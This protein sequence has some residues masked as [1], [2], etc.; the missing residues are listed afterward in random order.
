MQTVSLQSV[1]SV[2][3]RAPA[4][5]ARYRRGF[6]NRSA[7]FTLV[8]LC[9][10][11]VL[12]LVAAEAPHF[13]LL[14][15][16]GYGDVYVLHSVQQFQRTGT[17]YQDTSQP[18]YVPSVYSPAV[19]L[20][21]ALP[22]R[23][24]E[25]GNPFVLP[26]V[27][28]LI[29]FLLCVALTASIAHVL[30]PARSAWFWG[31]AM[32]CSVSAM[33]G[34]VLMLR[35]DFPG[36]VFSLLAIRLLIGKTRFAPALAGIAA[37]L[38][39]QFKFTFIAALAAGFLWLFVRRRWRDCA[40]F[41]LSGC[42]VSLGGYFLF[43]L[44]EPRMLAQILTFHHPLIDFPGLLVIIGQVLHEPVLLLGVAALPIV[45]RRSCPRW[46]LWMTFLAASLIVAAVTDLQAG[47]A[48]NYFY[49]A[50]FAITPLAVYTVL[51]LRSLPLPIAALCISLLL[52]LGPVESNLRSAYHLVRHEDS[53]VSKLNREILSIDDAIRGEHFFSTAPILALHGAD[54]IL[55]EPFLFSYL[56]KLGTLDARPLAERIRSQE[57]SAAVTF[58]DEFAYRSVALSPALVAAIGDSYQPYCEFGGMVFHFPRRGPVGALAARLKSIGCIAP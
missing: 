17:I 34:K 20:L 14:Q 21:L 9:L 45:L 50:L 43:A 19:Y 22:G 28:E 3:H 23:F 42:A 44:R 57:F 58:S 55:T 52:L 15:E 48:V 13:S 4:G 30:I 6:V 49:E 56:E 32:A 37:G 7:Y 27:L 1:V 10:A 47:G 26:R 46:N 5:A 25:L 41:I 38:A 8:L 11:A 18:P 40:S 2:L 16:A 53:R 54:P 29:S 24:L 12:A 35:G 31:L 51:R 39:M 36:L 33:Q